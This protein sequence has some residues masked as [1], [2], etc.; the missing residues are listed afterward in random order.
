MTTYN[1]GDKIYA[2]ANSTVAF[3]ATDGVVD[4]KKYALR[5]YG[6]FLADDPLT[7]YWNAGETL[8][9]ATGVKQG[10]Y[11]EF[12]YRANERYINFL[13]AKRLR[14]IDV[15]AWA[16]VQHVVPI[17]AYALD[18]ED[19]AAGEKNGGSKASG[20]NPNIVSNPNVSDT[21]AT[22][23]VGLGNLASRNGSATNNTI[24]IAA[25]AVAFVGIIAV[26]FKNKKNKK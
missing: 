17:Q 23:V 26:I 5:T 9:L 3:L 15:R 20:N 24:I 22:G 21:K 4:T 6:V 25:A 7:M 11:V 8:G 2:F 10:S 12:T 14:E 1:A 18:Q 19:A 13:G 16:Y